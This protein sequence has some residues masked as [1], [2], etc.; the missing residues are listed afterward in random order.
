M[1]MRVTK[2]QAFIL[3]AVGNCYEE[4]NKR[5]A[6]SPISV[7]INKSMFIKLAR[8]SKITRKKERALYKN[9]EA[10]EKLKL[11]SYIGKNLSLT[12]KGQKTFERIKKDLGPYITVKQVLSQDALQ[13]TT[14]TQTVLRGD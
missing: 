8:K 6:D 13:Y 2:T 5:F 10:L 4:C 12:K 14:K 9:L 1:I 11:L 3:F 7:K